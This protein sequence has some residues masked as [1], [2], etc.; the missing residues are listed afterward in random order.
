MVV[1][2]FHIF[3]IKKK[4]KKKNYTIVKVN[5]LP[6]LTFSSTL[7]LPIICEFVELKMFVGKSTLALLQMS[8]G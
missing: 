1:K 5:V 3:Y 8:K 2:Y 6:N 4:K 7:G